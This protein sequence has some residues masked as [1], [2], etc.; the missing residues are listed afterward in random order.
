M[1]RGAAVVTG[2]GQ[3]IGRAIA[4]RVA[5]TGRLVWCVDLDEEALLQMVQELRAAGGDVR[6]LSCDVGDPAAILRAWDRI[7]EE[8]TLVTALVNNAGIFLRDRALDVTPADWQR[9]LSVNLSGAF[10]MAQEAAGRLVRADRPGSLV[11]VASGQ[12]YR[13]AARGAAYA[14]SKAGL[15]NL[16]R[17]L[18]V[19]WGPVGIRVN[20]VVPGLTD[21][22]Q[23]R[24]VKGDADFV[25]AAE[26]TPLRRLSRPEDIAAMVCF[27]L[28]DEASSVTGQAFAVNGGRIMI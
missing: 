13:P 24:A 11:S 4:A 1:T 28:S 17:A 14:A 9:V 19:E 5:G 25:A 26:G 20:T 16:T 6:A 22:A 27:L 2:A 7:D 23:P 15:V 10:F 21:T 12:A 3:G 18:A 8:G